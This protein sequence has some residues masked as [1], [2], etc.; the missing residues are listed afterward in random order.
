MK[1]IIGFLI[2]A[3]LFGCNK[4]NLRSQKELEDKFPCEQK[5]IGVNIKIKNVGDTYFNMF[6]LIIDDKRIE[7][8]G[9]LV[10]E[11]SCFK[12]VDFIYEKNEF[13]IEIKKDEG[14]RRFIE[15][16][17]EDELINKID[18]G[19]YILLIKPF[20]DQ[21]KTPTIELKKV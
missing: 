12:N 14:N 19:N 9:C 18:Q 6:T 17:Y 5:D 1:K 2:F 20:K 8:P 21:S 3:L 4:P 15:V 7:F 11:E 13:D 10:N 16:R